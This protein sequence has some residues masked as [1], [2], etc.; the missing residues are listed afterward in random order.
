MG[1][2]PGR[3]TLVYTEVVDILNILKLGKAYKVFIFVF[4][5]TDH[6]YDEPSNYELL[7]R[8]PLQDQS[9]EQNYQSLTT[10]QKGK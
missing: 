3:R 6:K 1:F 4:I 7:R 10:S 5:F 2:L 9:D 8:N